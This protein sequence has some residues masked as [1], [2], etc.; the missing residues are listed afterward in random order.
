MVV[1]GEERGCGE[2]EE[3]VELV[4]GCERSSLV[5]RDGGLGGVGLWPVKILEERE[6]LRTS[7]CPAEPSCWPSTSTARPSEPEKANTTEH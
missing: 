2:N 4:G 5:Q 3:E 7:V 6:G 1:D